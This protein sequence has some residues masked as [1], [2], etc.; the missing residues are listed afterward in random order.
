MIQGPNDSLTSHNCFSQSANDIDLKPLPSR[1]MNRQTFVVHRG[2]DVGGDVLL[3]EVREDG[4]VLK[5][6]NGSV[7]ERVFYEQLVNMTYSPKNKVICLWQRSSGS[8]QGGGGPRC[9]S[10]CHHWQN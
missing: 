9:S 4:L 8:T 1:Q 5:L 2:T 6:T 3:L 10:H 7:G